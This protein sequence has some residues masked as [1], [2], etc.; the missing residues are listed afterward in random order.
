MARWADVFMYLIRFNMF[1]Q[2]RGFGFVTFAESSAVE[3][4]YSQECHISSCFD[5]QQYVL[6]VNNHVLSERKVEVCD[7]LSVT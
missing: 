3:V 5:M 6:S 4:R 2:P 1:L 7:S